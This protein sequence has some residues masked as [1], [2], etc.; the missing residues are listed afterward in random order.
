M[1]IV[2]IVDFYP[3]YRFGHVANSPKSFS[4]RQP[5]AH[6]RIL[7]ENGSSGGEIADTPIA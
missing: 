2:G 7:D 4:Y 6:A 3:E 1:L 5:V